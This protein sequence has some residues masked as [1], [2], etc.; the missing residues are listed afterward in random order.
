[1]ESILPALRRRLIP[2]LLLAALALSAAPRA[3]PAA[4]PPTKP[5]PPAAVPA[6]AVPAPA[7]KDDA[8]PAPATAGPPDGKW[9]KDKD[10]RQYYLDKLEKNPHFHRLHPPPRRPA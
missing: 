8:K 6:P 7:V 3:P 1:M 4:A 5:V 2:A 9:L 10:G